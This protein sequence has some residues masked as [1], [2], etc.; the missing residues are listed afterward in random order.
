M[1]GDPRPDA[2]G[3]LGLGMYAPERVVDNHWMEGIVDTS[4]E[5]IVTRTGIR[6]RRFAAAEDATSDLATR[7]AQAAMADAGVG[8]ED[9]DLIIC[10]RVIGDMMFPATAALVQRNL[11]ARGAAAYDVVGGCSGWVYALH[12]AR[13]MIAA[14]LYRRVL[15]IGAEVLSRILDFQDRSTCV[16]LGDAAGAVVLGPVPQ[17]QGI[18]SSHLGCDGNL[19][20]LM[21]LPGGGSRRPASHE[22]VEQRLH[23][24]RMNGRETYRHAV[25]VMEEA[26]QVALREAGLTVADVDLFV[27]HQ[28]NLRIMQAVGRRLGLDDARI[29]VTVDRYGNTSSASIPVALEEARAAGRLERGSVALL[30]SFGTGL[31]WGAAVVRW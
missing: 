19:W 10:A 31:A 8:P 24:F 11:G 30:V 22:T 7:A 17:G 20:E 9:V 27:P 5:W 15:V 25:Q 1:T 29:M 16:L 13:G 6:E 26:S 3:I 18:L 12:Q 14:G 4:D 2:V 23:Y 28:A 21:Y